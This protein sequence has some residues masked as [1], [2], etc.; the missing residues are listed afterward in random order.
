MNDSSIKER[1][2]KT[3]RP[4]A[5]RNTIAGGVSS[6]TAL[7]STLFLTPLVIDQLGLL[8]YGVWVVITQ[9]VGYAGILDTGLQQAVTKYVAS[10]KED[11]Q[12]DSV[13]RILS[14]A[15]AWQSFIGLM[16]IVVIAICSN[17]LIR[18]FHLEAVSP[19]QVESALILVGLGVA[20]GIPASVFAAGLRGYLRFELVSIIAIGAQAIRG[21]VIVLALKEGLG[22]VGLAVGN[23]VSQTFAAVAAIVLYWKESHGSGRIVCRPEWKALRQ[24]TAYTGYCLCGTAGWYLAYASSGIVI[25]ATLTT[26]D[27]AHFALALNLV[28]AVT[29]VV[30]SFAG[31]FLPLASRY[32]ARRDLETLQSVY[33]AG[34]RLAV[35]IGVPSMAV[36]LVIGPGLLSIWLSPEVATGSRPLVQLLSVA[37]L[38]VLLNGPGLQLALGLNL[39][40]SAAVLSLAEGAVNVAV[41]LLLAGPLGVAGIAVG[42]LTASFL[43]H[44]LVWP[45]RLRS[46][47]GLDSAQIWRYGVRPMLG[48]VGGSLVLLSIPLDHRPERAWEY[49]AWT[50]LAAGLAVWFWSLRHCL[51]TADRLI[52]P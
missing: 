18:W 24:I 11:G 13:P 46:Y 25:G 26:K 7:A 6:A 44:G 52:S 48:A 21:I 28:T 45:Y 34:L 42:T 5:I 33:L 47:L 49:L 39:Y 15:L 8:T 22:I 50:T 1:T 20:I 35:V 51:R 10:A 38:F 23:L 37:H 43:F 30:G 31:M 3:S 29:S 2:G 17:Y 12:T 27:V 14:T 32:D 9:L 36:C 19:S 41:S 40:R 16:V 4:S